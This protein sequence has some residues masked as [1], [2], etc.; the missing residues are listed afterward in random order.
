M[1]TVRLIGGPMD[2]DVV[3][4]PGGKHATF[5]ESPELPMIFD[6]TFATEAN[7]E[8]TIHEYKRTGPTTAHYVIPK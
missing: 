8:V 4:W 7:V 6:G 3:T 2:H 5:W 1:D